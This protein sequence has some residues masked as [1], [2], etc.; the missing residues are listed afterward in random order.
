MIYNKKEPK[1]PE[2]QWLKFMQ[3]ITS[4]TSFA[5]LLFD[6]VKFFTER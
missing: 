3:S 6:V 4:I 1:D 2:S 5:R